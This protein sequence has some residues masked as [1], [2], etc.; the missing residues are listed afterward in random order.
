MTDQDSMRRRLLLRDLAQDIRFTFRALGRN[1]GFAAVSVLSL[2]LGLGITAINAE[3]GE[4]VGTVKAEGHGEEAV[5][6]ADG[7]MK[8]KR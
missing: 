6:G 4:V 1:P 8:S 5:I 7:R 2:A 3:T